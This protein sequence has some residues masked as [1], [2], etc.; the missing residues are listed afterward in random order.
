M[1]PDPAEVAAIK[2]IPIPT[3]LP[4]LRRFLGMVGYY[5]RFIS[6]FAN[7]AKPLHNLLRK[8]VEFNWSS[9]CGKA[10]VN[11]QER[12]VKP[13]VLAYPNFELPFVI[14]TDACIIGLGAVL[15]QEDPEKGLCPIAFISRTLQPAER[16]YSITEQECLAVV[17]ALKI[18]R[19]YVFGKPIQV[20]TDHQALKWL[21]ST[22]N[23][24]GRLSR[25]ALT[26][27]EYN[28][29]IMYRPGAANKAADAL[30]RAPMVLAL[31][32]IAVQQKMDSE[33]GPIIS[34]LENGTLPSDET[35]AKQ[36]KRKSSELYKLYNG[37]LVLKQAHTR[38]SG[39]R[40][41][42]V[43]VPCSLRKSLLQEYHDSPL[44]GHVGKAKTLDH[45]QLNYYWSNM[46]KDVEKYV[47]QCLVCQQVKN[48][49]P[50]AKPALQ[51]IHIPKA[52][53]ELMAM[54]I[55][56]LPLTYA[57]NKYLLV[58]VDHL[59]KYPEL[60]RPWTG[61]FQIHEVLD[62]NNVFLQDAEQSRAPFRV[63]TRRIKKFFSKGQG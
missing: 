28:L 36:I 16:N 53:F 47:Q 50:H 43:V 6:H 39:D 55:M 46:A 20:V 34:Y 41:S 24:S 59:T 17:W 63:H 54:D 13:P 1:K 3:D 4:S 44:S 23:P 2:S 10:F 35:L 14:E 56:E 11:L 57:G 27:Q 58:F 21:F 31:V 33:L 38:H 12:L 51:S 61:P 19:P 52:P 40:P 32:D 25:W 8:N 18:F 42:R 48:P 45:L 30:S 62:N 22:K 26:L 9:E 7:L 5:R 37:Q 60:G 49:V 15:S 29:H